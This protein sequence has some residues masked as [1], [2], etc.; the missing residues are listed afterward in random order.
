MARSL[1]ASPEGRIRAKQALARKRWTQ[2]LLAEEVGLKTRQPVG[3]F[4]AGQAVDRRVFIA[5][6]KAV[7]TSRQ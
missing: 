1:Y 3:R 6:A 5:V 4:F 7:R 2:Q